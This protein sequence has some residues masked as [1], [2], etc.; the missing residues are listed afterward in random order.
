MLMKVA[1]LDRDGVIN[2]DTDYLY[3]IADFVFIDDVIAA[4]QTLQ[5]AG[6]ALIIVTNQ[7]GI[8]RGYYSE[9]DYQQLTAWYREQLQQ[10]GVTI[11]AVYHC[12]HTPED[13]CDCRKPKP[14]LFYQAKAQFPEVDFSR[15]LMVG[16]KFSDLE[17]A[18]AAGIPQLV[19]VGEKDDSTLIKELSEEERLLQCKQ[20]GYIYYR[21]LLDFVQSL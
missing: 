14:G 1:F 16:D 2:H 10:Q 9:Q 7:S 12:P 18:Q 4:L 5:Q 15:S 20:R 17:A 13:N 21:S 6:Y 3:K 11:T 19:L 8:G